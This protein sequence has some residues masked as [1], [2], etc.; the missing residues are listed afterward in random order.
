MRSFK[1]VF[2][3]IMKK[4]PKR[5]KISLVT[6]KFFVSYFQENGAND[7]FEYQLLGQN[8]FP[9]NSSTK[10]VYLSIV[11]TPTYQS[12]ASKSNY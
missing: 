12:F 8:P 3:G 7:F 6:K 2:I 10:N 1:K 5:N 9:H 4:N 11:P